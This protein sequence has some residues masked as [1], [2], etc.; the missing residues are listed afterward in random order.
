MR[1]AK[2][3]RDA[4]ALRVSDY[5]ISAE[6]TRGLEQT[7]TQEIRGAN[8]ECLVAVSPLDECLQVAQGAVGGRV[9]KQNRKV[10]LSCIQVVG[11]TSN[12]VDSQWSGASL[13]NV[14]RLGMAVGR[15]PHTPSFRLLSG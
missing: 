2:S 9:L 8:H 11:V 1:S 4:E 13:D 3:K 5:H 12:H 10:I 15:N 14:D 7:E 6:L